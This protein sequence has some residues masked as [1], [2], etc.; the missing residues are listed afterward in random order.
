MFWGAPFEPSKKDIVKNMIKLAGKIKNK[1]AVDLGSGD[2][3][4]TRELEKA[5]AIAYGIENNPFL[6]I[7]SRIK[8]KLQNSKS[9]IILNSFWSDD[10]SKYDVIMMFQVNYVMKKLEDKIKSECKK[11]TII[12]SHHWKFPNLKLKI[13]ENDI[14]VYEI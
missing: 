2:G 3:R 12:I 6:V 11:G 4:I 8:L 5:G 9:K 13:K 10:F 14:Y 7:Y 1:R